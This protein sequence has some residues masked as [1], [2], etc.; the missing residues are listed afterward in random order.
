MNLI[1]YLKDGTKQ[2]YNLQ[3]SVFSIKMTTNNISTIEDYINPDAPIFVLQICS[4]MDLSFEEKQ[5]FYKIYS[6][7]FSLIKNNS[8]LNFELLLPESNE[9][10]F[11]TEILNI[12]PISVSIADELGRKNIYDNTTISINLLFQ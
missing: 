1:I 7:I 6:K 10:I 5:V 9:I 8:I 4:T 2:E 12:R 3:D 11:N